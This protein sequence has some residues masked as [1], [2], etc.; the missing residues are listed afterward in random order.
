M[1][2]VDNQI[3][4]RVNNYE[5]Y[6]EV[7]S[8]RN[9]KPLIENFDESNL[10]SASYDIS[11]TSKIRKFK[12]SFKRIRLDDKDGIDDSFEEIDILLGYDL[13]PREYILIQLNEI[14]NMPNDL[15]AHVRP[16]TTFTKL[17]LILSCQ[18]L[19]PSY[20]GQLQLG[21]FNATPF[22]VEITPNLIIGQLVFEKLDLEPDGDNLYY[23]KKNA[24]YQ[25]EKGFVSSK[26]YEEIDHKFMKHLDA[27]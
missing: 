8:G 25:N 1:I 24:K 2:L 23:K 4:D 22:V 13:R 20:N 16:R 18:H 10:Q 6:K 5:E 26:I 7:Y 11:I 19:N 12:D 17:G 21:L 9:V 27:L 14:I 15:I 3:R